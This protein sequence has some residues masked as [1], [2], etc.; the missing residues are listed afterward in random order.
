MSETEAHNFVAKWQRLLGSS[1][2]GIE[3][4]TIRLMRRR[5][6]TS[7]ACCIGIALLTRLHPEPSAIELGL[8]VFYTLV[9]GFSVWMIMRLHNVRLALGQTN[10]AN[11]SS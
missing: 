9:C 7:V 1:K 2:T 3:A 11:R 4:E 6:Y 10:S 5:S 8:A